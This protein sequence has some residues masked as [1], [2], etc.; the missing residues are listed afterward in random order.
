MQHKSTG[1]FLFQV[2]ECTC[3]GVAAHGAIVKVMSAPSIESP[4]FSSDHEFSKKG[5]NG[6]QIVFSYTPDLLRGVT[7]SCFVCLFHFLFHFLL[8]KTYIYI[9]VS[10]RNG[11]GA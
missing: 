8:F 5:E 11:Q 3:Y 6:I 2:W 7:A 4:I 10:P 9:Y 1:P